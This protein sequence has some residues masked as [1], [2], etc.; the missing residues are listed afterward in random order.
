MNAYKGDWEQTSR[1]MK[2]YWSK[3]VKANDEKKK[4]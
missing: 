2:E 4:N 3:L 1:K